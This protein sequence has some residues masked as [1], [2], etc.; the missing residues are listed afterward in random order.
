MAAGGGKALWREATAWLAELGVLDQND[1]A[2]KPDATVLDFSLSLQVLGCGSPFCLLQ[3]PRAAALTIAIGSRRLPAGTG[4]CC[5]VPLRQRHHAGLH[6][7]HE[8]IPR[9]A[10]YEDAE[11]QHFPALPQDRVS[12]Q[13]SRTLLGRRTLLRLQFPARAYTCARGS[14]RR[15][16]AC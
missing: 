16:A 6:S 3:Q 7:R 12:H 14:D 1:V 2:L 5:A 4:W 15:A 10:V 13:G 8:R 11:H 9:Q